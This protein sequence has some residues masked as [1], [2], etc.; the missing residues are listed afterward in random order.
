MNSC[1]KASIY[2]FVRLQAIPGGNPPHLIGVGAFAADSQVERVIDEFL[3]IGAQ[4]EANGDSG[5][6]LDAGTGNI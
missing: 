3:G 2:L 4:V 1:M 5:R 6:W